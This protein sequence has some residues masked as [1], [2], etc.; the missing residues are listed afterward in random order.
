HGRPPRNR[1]NRME[2]NNKTLM[3]IVL[4]PSA[5][6]NPKSAGERAGS[7]E[8]RNE[9]VNPRTGTAFPRA[10]GR[11]IRPALFLGSPAGAA[12]SRA[13]AGRVLRFRPARPPGLG[14]LQGPTGAV[15]TDGER[16]PS[17]LAAD[18]LRDL[19]GRHGPFFAGSDHPEPGR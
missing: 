3:N 18:L 13:C 1:N 19:C 9:R 8:Y 2:E 4:R 17:F 7:K 12:G 11:R 14:S 10:P 5:G 15:A 6:R 16:K